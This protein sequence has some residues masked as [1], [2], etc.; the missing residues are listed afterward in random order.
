MISHVRQ[1]AEFTGKLA[2]IGSLFKLQD[3]IVWSL[4]GG[5]AGLA[6]DALMLLVARFRPFTPQP[7][8]LGAVAAG[9]ALIGAL[10][11]LLQR[12]STPVIAARADQRLSLKERLTTA[13]ELQRRQ[14]AGVLAQA[15]IADALWYARRIE[16][17]RSFPPR[18]PSREGKLLAAAVVVTAALIAI[19]NPGKAAIQKQAAVA[20]AINQEAQKLEKTA[21]DIRQNEQQTGNHSQDQQS[22]DQILS[23]LQ[24]Q[25][26]QPQ[27][28]AE[29]ALA[30]LESAQQKLQSNQDPNSDQL[31]EALQALAANL[32]DQPLLQKVAQDIR[33]G[34][35]NAA[36]NDLQAAGQ[37]AA[38]M[39]QDEK[40]RLAASLRAAAAAQ[41]KAGNSQLGDSLDQASDSL[42]GSAADTTKAF[43]QAAGNLQNAGQRAQ[44][45]SNL[46]KA[47]SQVQQSASNL[48]Q[49][50]GSNI[51]DPTAQSFNS[52]DPSGTSGDES[53]DGANS[54]MGQGPGS[55][56]G[57]NGQNGQGSGQGNGQGQ[58]DTGDGRGSGGQG[59]ET[60]Y[61]GEPGG[62][63]GVPGQQGANGK[64]STSDDDSLADPAQNGSNV[65]YEQVVGQYQQ[66]A[67]QAMDRAAVPLSYREIVKDYFSS[68]APRR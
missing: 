55:Q 60:V 64:V 7:W 8:L 49:Q 36:A 42:N 31:A 11:G 57:Q 24:K 1:E 6:I 34:D 38:G 62:P 18:V 67:S 44:A 50:T 35:Y 52:G 12:Y 2:E 37:Q 30:K 46:N 47:L 3:A 17:W 14:A 51:S 66:Q 33:S 58:G 32:D 54:S 26:R 22:I 59:G 65:P 43:R 20:T 25:L 4:R 48:A 27:L 10:V 13:L 5:C 56:S 21:V 61:T 45:Q 9:L 68:L 15:Q 28:S 40:D 53:A 39:S 63:R 23:E 29:D 41:A 19:P 16:P